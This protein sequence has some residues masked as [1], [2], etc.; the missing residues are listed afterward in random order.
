MGGEILSGKQIHEKN[1]HT[2]KNFGIWVRYDSR[3][4]THN[5][6]KEYR[7]I[8][9]VGAVSQMYAEMAGRHRALSQSIQIIRTAHLKASECKRPHMQQMLKSDLKFPLL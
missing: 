1:A 9:L 8:T 5:M 6:Y 7:D 3:S 4:G 2:V